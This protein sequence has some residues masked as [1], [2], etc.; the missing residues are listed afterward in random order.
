MKKLTILSIF[1]LCALPVFGQKMTKEEKAAAAQ[2]RYEAALE[3]INTRSFVLVPSEWTDSEGEVVPNDN[4]SIFL[5]CEGDQVFGQG[6][7][8][9]DNNNDNVAE[10][11]TYDVIVDKKGNVK[12][13]MVINGRMWKGTYRI[14]MRKGDNQADVIFDPS[15]SG[16]T[17]RFHGPIVPL[18]GASYNKHSHPI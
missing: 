2:L 5:S 10:V 12:L 9:T 13:I 1:M 4:N 11:T 8:V 6:V 3:S 15:G 17:R 7:S 18:V 16:T 14:T